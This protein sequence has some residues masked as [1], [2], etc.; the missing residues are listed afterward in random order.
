M[1]I[2]YQSP[3]IQ[4]VFTRGPFIYHILCYRSAKRQGVRGRSQR[5]AAES[6]AQPTTRGGVRGGAANDTQGESDNAAN[7]TRP[8]RW[9]DSCRIW[10]FCRR[11]VS[12][13]IRPLTHSTRGRLSDIYQGSSSLVLTDAP[14]HPDRSHQLTF[15]PDI[16]QRD[17]DGVP[18]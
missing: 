15:F 8:A 9:N 13:M 7:D 16:L 2:Q 14:A 4:H 12:Q 5:H 3:R 10:E 18:S 11:F 6:G 17:R 1:I